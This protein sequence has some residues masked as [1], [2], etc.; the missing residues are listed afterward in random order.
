[1]AEKLEQE[2]ESTDTYIS[3]NLKEVNGVKCEAISK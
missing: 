2:G 1:M 3:N